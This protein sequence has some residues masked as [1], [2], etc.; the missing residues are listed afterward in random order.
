MTKPA[1]PAKPTPPV[2]PPSHCPVHPNQRL[3][4]GHARRNP[5]RRRQVADLVMQVDE[6]TGLPLTFAAIA[7]QLGISRERVRQLAW[8]EEGVRGKVKSKGM[9][10]LRGRRRYFP[11]KKGEKQ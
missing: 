1:K 4:R 8:E 6:Q 3:A 7:D 10:L 2:R 11:P 9:V 5:D